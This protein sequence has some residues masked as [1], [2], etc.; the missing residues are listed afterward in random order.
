MT[1]DAR[2]V[3]NVAC[4][5]RREADNAARSFQRTGSSVI[6]NEESFE[7]DVDKNEASNLHI[8]RTQGIDIIHTATDILVKSIFVVMTVLSLSILVTQGRVSISR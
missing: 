2:S 8:E 3:I 6:L 5:E 7:C 1:K 4:Q